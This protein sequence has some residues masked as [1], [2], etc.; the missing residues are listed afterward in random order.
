MRLQARAGV[1]LK[2]QVGKDLLPNSYTWLL[3]RLISFWVVGLRDEAPKWLLSR[4]C[5]LFLPHG[6]PQHDNLPYQHLKGRVYQTDRSYKIIEMTAHHL[7]SILL[8]RSKLL[9]AR[10]PLTQGGR[11]SARM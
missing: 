7:C 9:E 8:N 11:D 5:S 4:G 2:A 6:M 10:L 1:S 3:A